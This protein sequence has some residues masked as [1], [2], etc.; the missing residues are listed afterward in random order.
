MKN[1]LALL[2]YS[3]GILLVSC[4][5]KQAPI[6]PDIPQSHY[7]P[8]T[9]EH[10]EERLKSPG[11]DI[12]T[13]YLVDGCEAETLL[14]MAAK[15]NNFEL[16]KFLI[17][18]GASVEHSDFFYLTHPLHITTDLRIIEFFLQNGADV[19]TCCGMSCVTL[20]HAAARNGD[21]ELV[22]LCFKYGANPNTRINGGDSPMP[23]MDACQAIKNPEQGLKWWGP[24]RKRAFQYFEVIKLLVKNGADI[25]AFSNRMETAIDFAKDAGD[26]RVLAFLQKELRRKRPYPY[27]IKKLKKK[28]TDPQFDVNAE[29]GSKWDRFG[30]TLLAL[31]AHN[32][33]LPYVEFL[34]AHG[35]KCK[36]SA[37]LEAAARNGNVR[38]MR[39]LL[40]TKPNLNEEHDY[41]I[42]SPLATACLQCKAGN[43]PHL[44]IIKLLVNS[45]ANLNDGST[46]GRTPLILL[47][48]CHLEPK[49]DDP[50]SYTWKGNIDAVEFLLKHGANVGVEVSLVFKDKIFEYGTV[51]NIVRNLSL[52][53]PDEIKLKDLL[54]KY[55]K[56]NGSK[57]S[58]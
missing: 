50:Y 57:E 43:S 48:L 45:G 56:I 31:A 12:N 10:L 42:M 2:S 54:E 25:R 16:V 11:F 13:R 8:Y 51:L 52:N 41:G 22:K 29:Y 6:E 5:Y 30:R 55:L 39:L 27:S 20:L 1:Y 24:E 21:L 17:A 15:Q 40:D 37:P 28:V 3:I 14:Y 36:D 46:F 53:N 47:V 49:K 34:I 4:S 38:I 7:F 19:G 9:I 33:D 35:A 58:R 23:L 26:K 18:H 32:N 44:E